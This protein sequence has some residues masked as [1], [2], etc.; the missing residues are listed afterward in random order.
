MTAI[1]DLDTLIPTLSTELKNKAAKETS[2]LSSL[3]AINTTIKTNAGTTPDGL[4]SPVPTKGDV[5]YVA[6]ASVLEKILTVLKELSSAAFSFQAVAA[7]ASLTATGSPG[8]YCAD[9]AT[10]TF[11]LCVATNQWVKLSMLA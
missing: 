8:Q 10:S 7:P 3:A 9:T 11:Y 2:A 4:V 1:S 6:F 5:D